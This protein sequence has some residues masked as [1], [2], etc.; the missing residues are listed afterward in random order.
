MPG[1]HFKKK[2]FVS[3]ASDLK[4]EKDYERTDY[5]VVWNKTGCASKE[6]LKSSL[7]KNCSSLCG[8]LRPSS[9]ILRLLLSHFNR[10]Y[11]WDDDL[12]DNK[13]FFKFYYPELKAM[14]KDLP[15]F[16]E[17]K[18]VT[19]ISSNKKSKHPNE[20]STRKEKR[21]SN[22][23]KTKAILIST[24]LPGKKKGIK[25]IEDPSITSLRH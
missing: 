2:I 16:E 25:T 1:K 9:N 3:Y 6:L 4:N 22:F 15:S 11:T 8:S 17:K 7:R 18:L 13:K 12:V 14:M 5:V 21:S 24:A 10:I 23:L 19:Q 20:S